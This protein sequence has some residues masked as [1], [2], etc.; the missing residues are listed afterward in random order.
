MEGVAFVE[1]ADLLQRIA[2]LDP[3]AYGNV[4]GDHETHIWPAALD[5]WLY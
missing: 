2:R 4:G 5:R 1:L 3:P